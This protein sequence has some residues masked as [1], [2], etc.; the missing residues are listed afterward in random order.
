MLDLHTTEH[1]YTEVQP[2][3]LVRDEALFGT[4]Q[5]P[6]FEE[7]LFFASHRR[8]PAGP[9][10]D[11]RSAADQSRARR[12]RRAR[13]AAAALHRADAVLPLGGRLGRPRH[14]RHA[15]PAPVLQGRA[16]LDHRRRRASLAEHERMTACAEEVL[17][18]LGLPFRTDGAVHR[19]HGLRRAQDLRHR[20]LAARPERLSAKSRPARSA[21]I[22]RRAAWMR[23]TAGK[24]DKGTRFVHTLNGS[25]TAVGRA[26]IAVLENY[27]NEDGS[28]TIPEALA[29][30]H[31][32]TDQDRSEVRPAA[33][34]ILLTNDD[35][36]HAEG[37][38]ALERIA[39]HA[40]RRRL[41]GRAGARPVA[42]S[43]IRCRSPSR[44]GCARS[45]RSTTPLRG[46][47]TDCVIM[48]VQEDDAGTA[49][50]HPVRRQ[51]RL[52]HRRRRD[53]FRHHRRRDGRHACSASAPS[54]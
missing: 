7:D 30:L 33:M 3:L 25:G 50:P 18:R 40:L 37:L 10:P 23:A 53:L 16:G 29:A 8:W 45:A 42:A 13:K 34:R 2:P 6:K 39:R 35:G 27:Q 36:I 19:R 22:S 14:A 52:Q 48:G 17:K 28:V 38:A 4:G 26:L 51:F 15:A 31:G 20:G 32:R 5:L 46:T 11:R 54:R 41:G 43:R 47:P 44:C 9:H 49:G 21:A 24:D 12:N 1:G